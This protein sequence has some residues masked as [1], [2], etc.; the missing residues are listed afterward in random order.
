[1]S[2]GDREARTT[3]CGLRHEYADQC[4]T[5]CR[6]QKLDVG[7]LPGHRECCASDDFSRLEY[8]STVIIVGN[9]KVGRRD[10]PL[11]CLY[12]CVECEAGSGIVTCRLVGGEGATQRASVAHGGISNVA[13]QSCQHW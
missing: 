13:H 12:R 5:S 3:V 1:M 6:I 2:T 11:S 9:E 8:C 10:F 7:R 4:V